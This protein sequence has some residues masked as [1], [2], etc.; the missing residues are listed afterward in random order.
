MVGFETTNVFLPDASH[1]CGYHDTL[2]EEAS[3]EKQLLTLSGCRIHSAVIAVLSCVG[4]EASAV[5]WPPFIIVIF[6]RSGLPARASGTLQPQLPS[7]IFGKSALKRYLRQ[8]KD[9]SST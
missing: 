5:L 4:G 2:G 8:N 3:L 7:A 1:P 9:S 6:S